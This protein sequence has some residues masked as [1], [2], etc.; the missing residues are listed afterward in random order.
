MIK[1]V[2]PEAKI[3]KELFEAVGKLVDEVSLS[4]TSEGVFLRA[5]D[6]SQ[7]ALIE[8]NLPRDMFLEY[9]VEK[10]GSLGFSTSNIQKVLKHVKKGENLVVWSDGN[11]VNFRI[12]GL[13]RREYRFRNL[14]VPVID[15][16]STG[17]QTNVRAQL[18]ASVVNHAIQDAEVVGTI[19][20]IEA[21]S[22]EELVFRGRGTGVNET[23]LKIGSVG[24]VSLEVD[25]PSK[26]QYDI[27]YL[28]SVMKLCRVSDVVFLGFSSDS[29]LLLDF[30]IGGTGKVR[31]IMAPV[32]M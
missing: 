22:T 11:Y 8:V 19:I 26:S 4:I 18:I 3:L 25:E 17:L 31:Y 10:E 29:P 21:P 23:R 5:M 6:I 32:S 27:S 28:R 24:L 20:E 1:I 13:V 9:T 15:I 2:I 30:Q 12:E 14:E 16:P 7:I